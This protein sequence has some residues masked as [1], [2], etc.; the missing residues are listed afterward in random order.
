MLATLVDKLPRGDFA[1]EVKWDGVRAISYLSPKRL[2]ILSRN[3]L[4]ITHRY[5]ELA[6]IIATR[7]IRSAVLDG[8]IVAFAEDGLPSFSKLQRRML[9]GPKADITG[10]AAE[11]PIHYMIFDILELNGDSLL[12]RKYLDRR[13]VLKSLKLKNAAWSVPENLTGDIEDILPK[14]A[15]M[16]LEGIMAKRQDSE[17]LPGMRSM[18]WLKLK[19]MRRQELVIA[20]YERGQ[21]AR[22]TTIGALLL[23]YYDLPPNVARRRGVRQQLMYAGKCGTGF[24]DQVLAELLQKLNRLRVVTP[25]FVNPPRP[26]SDYVFTKPTLVG[27]F[28]YTEWTRTNTLRHPSFKGLRADKKPTEVVQE[29]PKSSK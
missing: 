27:E 15:S 20:G 24:T 14:S 16:G 23:G 5:P 22:S 18:D 13:N 7:G 4:D 3:D 10:I 6:S 17:Y 29:L 2:R 28:Q 25:A 1:F 12:K 19:N 9:L 21:G 11:T 8:E 26:A